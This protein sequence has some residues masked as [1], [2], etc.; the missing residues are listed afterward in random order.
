MTD[1]LVYRIKHEIILKG[2]KV[3]NNYFSFDIHWQQDTYSYR[4]GPISILLK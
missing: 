3:I 2:I 4:L 1:L